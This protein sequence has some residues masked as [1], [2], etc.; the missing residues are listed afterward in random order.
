MTNAYNQRYLIRVRFIV[1]MLW[2]G[3][4]IDAMVC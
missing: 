4:S 2:D 1:G 3:Y